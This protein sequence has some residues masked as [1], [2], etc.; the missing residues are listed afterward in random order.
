MNN[1]R[2][3]ALL[4]A[5]LMML[6]SIGCAAGRDETN[7]TESA[8]TD[9]TTAEVTTAAPEPYYLDT[10][11]DKTF[12]G[13]VFTMIGEDYE[14]RPNF[15]LQ[16]QTGT[17]INDAV[18]ERQVALESRYDID[19]EYSSQKNRGDCN[20]AVI[21]SVNAGDDTYDIV[22]NSMCDGAAKLV[23]QNVLVDMAALPYLNFEQP[24]WSQTMLNAYNYK[25]HTYL[26]VGGSSPSYYLSAVVA[27]Y[28]VKEAENFGLPNMYELVKEGKWTVDKM[29]ELM[30]LSQKDL[31]GDGVL[32]VA[33]DF[34]PLVLSS[35]TGRNLFVAAGG[36]SVIRTEDG[37]FAMNIGS[38]ESFDKLEALRA[39]FGSRETSFVQDAAEYKIKEFTTGHTMF[40]LT[41]MMF[42]NM[43]LRDM[44]ALYGVLPLPKLDENQKDYITCGNAY[45]PCGMCIP[46]SATN[47]EMSALIAEAMG[48]LGEEIIRPAIY[49]VTLH[50]K[51]AQ[52][53]DSSD[54]LELIYRDIV[55]DICAS[56]NFGQISLRTRE[57]VTGQLGNF[58]SVYKKL[59]EKCSTE[60]ANMVKAVESLDSSAK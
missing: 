39:V 15:C 12:G 5:A 44:E 17:T 36:Q 52:D 24:W 32:R 4:L 50:G 2:F 56:Y 48:F 34:I 55:F 11:S 28:N 26:A 58:T 31:D 42:G 45:A 29:G 27:L 53:K 9:T 46:R 51:L 23:L 30:A 1:T 40:A 35:E 41:A 57:Y 38:E 8:A 14:Q 18:Y 49:D 10:L 37:G 22:F 7:D 60:L 16:E 33:N 54:M 43:E 19:I 20:T 3:L 59:G 6:S 21:N 25:N 47:T 13:E